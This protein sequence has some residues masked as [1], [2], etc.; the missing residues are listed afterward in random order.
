MRREMKPEWKKIHCIIEVNLLF[1][2]IYSIVCGGVCVCVCV[3]VWWVCVLC[4]CVVCVCV[5]CVCVCVCV[6][7]VCVCVCVCVVCVCV[8]RVLSKYTIIYT[9]YIKYIHLF[10]HWIS[11]YMY[12]QHKTLV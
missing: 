6:C 11:K 3:C 1:Y 5:L 2:N 10:S 4:V 7:S 12:K 8:E 9:L